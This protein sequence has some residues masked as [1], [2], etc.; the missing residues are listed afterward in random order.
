MANDDAPS[1]TQ[2]AATFAAKLSYDDL[3]EETLRLT[4]RCILDGLAVMIGGTEQA[5][6]DVLHRYV[7]TPAHAV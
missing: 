1:L 2:Q 3:T 7:I 5:A 4:R 6:L